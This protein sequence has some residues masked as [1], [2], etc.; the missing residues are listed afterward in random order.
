MAYKKI[1]DYKAYQK[2]YYRKH[3]KIRV[4]KPQTSDNTSHKETEHFKQEDAE[5]CCT[6]F[7]CGKILT[8]QETLFGN[9]CID[10][11]KNKDRKPYA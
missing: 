6:F 9:L 10:H 5:M 8:P 1:Q 4:Y 3:R 11:Q 2:E 7:G